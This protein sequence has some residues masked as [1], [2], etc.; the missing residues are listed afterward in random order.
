MAHDVFISYATSD[1]PVA[2]AVCAGLEARGL[3]CWIAPRDILPGLDWGAAIIDA[4]TECKAMVLV[5][6]A[7]ANSSKQIKREVERAV[8]KGVTIIPLRIEDVP[9]GKT[10]EYF[11]STPHWMDALS[12]PLEPHVDRLAQTI[13]SLLA[14]PS[15]ATGGI[16]PPRLSETP[17]GSAPLP[18]PPRPPV[19][20]A[21]ARAIRSEGAPPGRLR[22]AHLLGAAAVFLGL[23]AVFGVFR[24]S[25]P[26][27]VSLQFPSQILAN[28]EPAQGVI[29]FKAN[30]TELAA[31]RFDVVQAA[32]FPSLSLPVRSGGQKEGSFG[33]S[34]Q[35]AVPQ[36]VV[37]QAVLV[38]RAGRESH[39]VKFSFDV[40]PAPLT[41]P[42]GG[43]RR[44]GPRGVEIQA[45][46]GFRFRLPR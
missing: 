20:A 35:T 39:P 23:L 11:I 13:R 18:P 15:R 22:P 33:F 27:I 17:A 28:N 14:R 37:L 5:F 7:S 45:P 30:K 40:A 26:Q 32:S 29:L 6:S 10:L 2:D 16:A 36:H 25:A 46:N 34:L 41:A 43:R 24:S 8:A 9:L 19:M 42:A 44:S 38:D 3:R 12:S 4:I 1:K 21:P 31:A